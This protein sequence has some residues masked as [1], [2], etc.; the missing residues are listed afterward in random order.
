MAP[1]HE[2]ARQACERVLAEDRQ[3]NIDHETW[4]SAIPILDRMLARGT[5][6]AGAYE[7]VFGKLHEVRPHALKTF[8]RVVVETAVVWS[9]EK[10]AAARAGR[11]ELVVVNKEIA[12]TASALAELLDRRFDLHNRSGFYSE[13]HYSICGLI[14]AAG[15]GNVQFTG[16]VSKP[17]ENL[18]FEFAPKYWPTLSAL[19]H[20]LAKDARKADVRA[21]DPLTAAATEGTRNSKAGYIK[22]LFVAIEDN[23]GNDFPHLPMGFKLTDETIASLVNCALDLGPD[24]TVD[25]PYVKRLRQRVREA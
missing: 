21:S 3:Y 25:G 19:M 22:A 9:P 4:H 15:Q 11:A 24:D 8:F 17:L 6:L 23:C 12:D 10:N 18:S 14:A 1:Q 2:T 5:E 7:E 13:T 20:E 16:W